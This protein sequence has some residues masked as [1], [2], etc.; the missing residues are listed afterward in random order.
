MDEGDYKHS[1]LT[2]GIIKAYYNVYNT[3]G[4][5]FLEK[6]YENAM[7]IELK[8]M[9]L[10]VEKQKQIEVYYRE[11]KVGEYY[12]DLIVNHDVIVELK[13]A[14]NLTEAQEYQLVNYLKATGK[15]VGLLLNFGL[16]PQFK[17]KVCTNKPTKKNQRESV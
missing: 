14:D 17:R 2:Q 4:H 7:I 13:V 6:V 1:E 12:A 8:K 3:L 16:K 9:G 5:G 15:E 11:E 10:G